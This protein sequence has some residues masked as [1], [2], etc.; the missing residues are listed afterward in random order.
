MARD[1]AGF[2]G[3]LDALGVHVADNSAKA[4]RDDW[5]F[6]LTEEPS[7]KVTG[8][9]LHQ[10]AALKDSIPVTTDRER[11]PKLGTMLFMA[12]SAAVAINAGKVAF[13]KDP[14]AINYP[15]WVAFAKYSYQQIRWD[16]LTKPAAR[17]AHVFEAIDTELHDVYRQIDETISGRSWGT[18]T[19]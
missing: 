14:M 6:S 13:T 9:R 17:Y 18:V 11:M 10:G 16:L 8:E 12:N 15:Q 19:M 2:L 5:V 7:K 4:R 1:E 3:I